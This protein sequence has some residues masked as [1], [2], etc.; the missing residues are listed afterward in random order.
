MLLDALHA[1][2][3]DTSLCQIGVRP[4]TLAF[5]S[6]DAG[7]HA[8]YAFF[9]EG[10]AGRMLAEADL[11]ALPATVTALHF[12]SFSLA[13]E[14]CGSAYETLA[15]NEG[16]LRVI[17]LDPNIR[18]TLIKNREG[19]VDRLNRM[20]AMADIIKLSDD[21]LDW[22]APV[23]GF[24]G[25]AGDWLRAGAK[26]VILTRGGEGATAITAEHEVSIPAVATVVADTI[27]AGDTFSAGV[28]TALDRAGD[29]NKTAIAA[30]SPARLDAVLRFAAKA[31]SITASRPGADPPWSAE[32]AGG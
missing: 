18:P 31:A 20:A 5:V 10:S 6:L 14:P 26:L 24:E 17:S 28:L 32:I 27:G 30:L 16:P 2:H 8:R 7:G 11:P 29:L 19:Y 21:D 1:S 23:D 25:M 13:Q 15:R 22:L 9:D 12:G 3:V 4:T